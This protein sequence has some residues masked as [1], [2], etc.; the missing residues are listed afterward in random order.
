MAG[1]RARSVMRTGGLASVL[2][3]LLTCASASCAGVSA[4]CTAGC[5]DAHTMVTCEGGPFGTATASHEQ[6]PPDANY[7][8]L[9]E[10]SPICA[11]S[12]QPVA[13]CSQPAQG[14]FTYHG[15]LASCLAGYPLPTDDLTACAESSQDPEAGCFECAGESGQRDHV[16]RDPR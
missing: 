9:Y 12:A 6:C 3:A 2:L 13:E 5:A 7:C 8:V 16:V 11:M 10:G 15:T 1:A 14:C 4:D